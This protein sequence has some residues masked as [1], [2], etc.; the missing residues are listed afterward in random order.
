MKTIYRSEFESWT[1]KNW[2]DYLN[3]RI[4]IFL[5]KKYL[6]EE[7]RETIIIGTLASIT[8]P[9]ISNSLPNELELNDGNV[10]RFIKIYKIAEIEIID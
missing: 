8:F 9:P 3:R 10:A 2:E 7:F 6:R 1:F 4:A 5:D